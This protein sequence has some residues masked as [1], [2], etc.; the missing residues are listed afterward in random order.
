MNEFKNLRMLFRLRMF[1]GLFVFALLAAAAA[2][3]AAPANAIIVCHDYALYRAT[4][5]DPRPLTSAETNGTGI[6]EIRRRLK[7]ELGYKRFPITTAAETPE[8]A[9]KYLK[10]GDVILLRDDHSGYVNSDGKIDHFIQVYGKSGTK[11]DASKLPRHTA[12]DTDEP[13]PAES[14]GGLYLGD[15]LARFL[16]RPFY[17][18]PAGSVEIWRKTPTK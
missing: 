17:K 6:V 13:P 18:G 4:G 7:D 2:F 8:F 5:Q 16:K 14:V 11:Y 10:P 3:W 9:A 15:T 12:P 1:P